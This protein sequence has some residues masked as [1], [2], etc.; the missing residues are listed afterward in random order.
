MPDCY[1]YASTNPIYI[2]SSN[3]KFSSKSSANYFIEWLNRLELAASSDEN[4]RTDEE[5]M[6]ILKDISIAR[7]FYEACAKNASID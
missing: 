3:K 5:K 4:Y 6:M 7:K 2:T 1:P